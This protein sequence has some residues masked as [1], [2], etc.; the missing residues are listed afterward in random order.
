MPGAAARQR[1]L[2]VG[3]PTFIP[4]IGAFTQINQMP[5]DAETDAYISLGGP[6]L[7]TVGALACY[8]LGRGTGEPWLVAVSYTGFMINLINLIPVPPLDGG[9]I[10]AVL[11]PR[12]WLLGIPALV[13]LLFYRFSPILLVVLIMAAPY[14]LAALR[15][16]HGKSPEARAYYE[17]SNRVRWEYAF[18]Y[19]VLV[20]FLTMM[21]HDTEDQLHSV[22]PVGG[23]QSSGPADNV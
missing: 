12:I 4:F 15:G 3:W 20:G 1:R 16:L 8:A 18:Y 2:P 7:G 13:A 14:G 9:R 21:V 5:H 22:A 6:L 10:T 11:S 17:V 19:V 23:V